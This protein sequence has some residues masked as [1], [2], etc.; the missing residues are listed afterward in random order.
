[1]LAASGARFAESDGANENLSA[2]LDRRKVA[3]FWFA[4]L[5]SVFAGLMAIGHAAAI[6]I[7]KGAEPALA[8]LAAISI[9]IGS[10]LGGF[11]SG[12]LVDRWPALRFLVGLPLLSALSLLAIGWSAS[13][14]L[15][16]I[17]LSLVGFAYGSI[18]AVYPVVISDRF[19][20]RGPQVYGQ[21]FVAWGLAGLLAPWSAGLIY[22]MR[23]GYGLA[24]AA[25]ALIAVLSALSAGRFRFDEPA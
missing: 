2:P 1:M 22:D 5:T 24:M 6:A 12:Y 17:L 10:A 4:Y 23:A 15:C 19:G 7:S 16:V 25:A 8:T 18:I 14:T 3:H 9:G 20:D 13:A 11:L 21:V